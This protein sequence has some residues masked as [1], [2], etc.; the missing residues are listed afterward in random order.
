MDPSDSVGVCNKEPT[1]R[2]GRGD[3]DNAAGQPL[4]IQCHDE[5]T[6]AEVGQAAAPVGGTKV[7]GTFGESRANK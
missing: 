3:I 7:P 4:P 2:V 6:M 5:V 1:H